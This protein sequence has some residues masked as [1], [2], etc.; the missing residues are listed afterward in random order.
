MCQVGGG[1]FGEYS[2]NTTG[3]FELAIDGRDK[4][5]RGAFTFSIQ[6]RRLGELHSIDD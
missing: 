2:V 3:Y 1:E 4:M 6:G 5:E